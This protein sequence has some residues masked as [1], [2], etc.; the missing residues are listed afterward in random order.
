MGERWGWLLRCVGPLKEQSTHTDQQL[1]AEVCTPVAHCACREQLSVG[2]EVNVVGGL[3]NQGTN[4]RPHLPPNSK[5]LNPGPINPS[6]SMDSV[7]GFC[8]AN[9][10]S[11]IVPSVIDTAGQEPS[12]KQGRKT[13]ET[14]AS[15]G[16]GHII[17]F[18]LH[19]PSGELGTP[20]WAAFVC[21]PIS[22]HR[23]ATLPLS[24]C[25]RDPP[26]LCICAADPTCPKKAAG[27]QGSR[28]A[29]DSLPQLPAVPDRHAG[30]EPAHAPAIG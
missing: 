7:C 17:A 19:R 11:V 6:D 5:T 26:F 10:C 24:S 21:S 9:H 20:S 23:A 3:M 27:Q 30:S 25:S 18:Y 8:R 15:D 14:E 4:L 13:S 22:H 12:R 28:L 16:V 29:E 2:C 1:V